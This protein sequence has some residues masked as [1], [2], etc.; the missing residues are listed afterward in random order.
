MS[1]FSNC[2][3]TLDTRIRDQ[4]CQGS[5]QA[6]TR[7]LFHREYLNP[8][9]TSFWTTTCGRFTALSTRKHNIWCTE[10]DSRFTLVVHTF[11]LYE[12]SYNRPRPLYFDHEAAALRKFATVSIVSITIVEMSLSFPCSIL[13]PVS[14]LSLMFSFSM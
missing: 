13:L 5:A 10:R 14:L 4:I 9:P 11:H 3:S 1:D 8:S 12:M 2:M 6:S 7:E